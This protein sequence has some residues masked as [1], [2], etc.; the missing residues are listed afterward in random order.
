MVQ[1][2]ACGLSV[3]LVMQHSTCMISIEEADLLVHQRAEKEVPQSNV[4]PGECQWEHTTTKPNGHRTRIRD[5]VLE[6]TVAYLE[7]PPQKKKKHP[8]SFL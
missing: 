4:K 1:A 3:Y 5:L 7:C 8:K 6:C 2:L